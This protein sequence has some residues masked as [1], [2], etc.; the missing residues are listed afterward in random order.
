[1]STTQ[2]QENKFTLIA[3]AMSPIG[4]TV[5][6]RINVEDVDFD[7]PTLDLGDRN[8]SQFIFGKNILTFLLNIFDY[9]NDVGAYCATVASE[10]QWLVD[11][12]V[13][14]PDI[15]LIPHMYKLY[16]KLHTSAI[17]PRIDDWADRMLLKPGVREE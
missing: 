16:G 9:G 3:K 2:T 17:L 11:R 15:I 13:T 12:K 8:E 14:L 10:Q 1:M 5:A 6:I 7:L 4:A